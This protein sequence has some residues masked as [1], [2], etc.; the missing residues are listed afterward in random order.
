M[1]R[2]S[3]NL[4]LLF[5]E[6]DFMQRF[7]AAARSG[8]KAVEVQFPYAWPLPRLT[9]ALEQNGLQL[10]LHNLPP[11]NWEAGERGIACLPERQSEF[12]EG[13][14]QAVEYALALGCTRLNC[15]V[16]LTPT[17]EPSERIFRTLVDNLQ[18]AAQ[19]LQKK[20]IKLLIETLN[21]RDVPGFHLVHTHQTKA[22]IEAVQHPNLWL[23]LDV[24][25]MQ[26]M[27]GDLIRTLTE[28]LHSIGHIQIA[29]NPGRHE[30]GS[31]EINFPNIFSTLD[32]VGYQG[33]IGCEY[34]PRGVTTDGLSWME[35]YLKT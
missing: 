18:F 25:H 10:V 17:K 31:G 23:Q 7:A 16:G 4:T 29:D 33:W 22:L 6:V 14:D 35:P 28:N 34:I 3:A 15:L 8:F 20:G 21:D 5:N 24:Y 30:P 19:A 13:V 32:N 26:V 1:P 2:F 11:G 9:E 12:R 27:D